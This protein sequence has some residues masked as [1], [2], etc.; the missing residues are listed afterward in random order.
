MHS[1]KQILPFTTNEKLQNR[2]R[3]AR[4]YPK[5]F[6]TSNIRLCL[7]NTTYMHGMITSDHTS[8]FEVHTQLIFDSFSGDFIYLMLKSFGKREL[9]FFASHHDGHLSDYFTL[10]I[11]K[12]LS[13]HQKV[14]LSRLFLF[15]T[16]N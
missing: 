15:M 3:T 11:L 9:S 10:V 8:R 4:I 2:T 5:D 12:T 6:Y 1:A 16:R 13:H 7:N 14:F